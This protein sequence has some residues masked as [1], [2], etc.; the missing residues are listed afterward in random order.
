M[1]IAVVRSGGKQYVVSEGAQLKV[2]KLQAEVGKPVEFADVL[3]VVND[4]NVQIGRPVLKTS[5]KAVVTEQLKDKK[6]RVFR[7]KAKTG[8]HKTTGHRQQL[9]GVKIEKIGL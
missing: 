5:V 9:T 2:E 4:N 1:K 7:Y 8:Y 3:L 6:I